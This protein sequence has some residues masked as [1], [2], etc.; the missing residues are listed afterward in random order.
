MKMIRRKM[1]DIKKYL[2]GACRDEKYVKNEK[3]TGWD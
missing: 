2:N 1:G 3:Y